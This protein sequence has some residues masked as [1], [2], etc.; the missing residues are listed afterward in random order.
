MSRITGPSKK[1]RAERITKGKTAS[2]IR[3]RSSAA[4]KKESCADSDGSGTKC[5][6][7]LRLKKELQIQIQLQKVLSRF[8]STIHK[9]AT[10][11]AQTHSQTNL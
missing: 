6:E 9:S 1:G 3:K 10:G 11:T 7:S 8:L 2:T 4:G 5:N